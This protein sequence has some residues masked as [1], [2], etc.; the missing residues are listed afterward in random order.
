MGIS[1]Q[2]RFSDSNSFR[3]F[4]EGVEQL[5]SYEVNAKAD[6]LEKAADKLAECVANYP[7]ILPRLYLGI[8]RAEQ[9]EELEEAVHLL[10]EV[11]DRNVPELRTTATYYLAEAYLL[12]YTAEDIAYADTL[13]EQV[14]SGEAKNPKDRARIQELKLR[15]QGLRAFIYVREYLWKKRTD[16]GDLS[17]EHRKAV[18]R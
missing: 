3:L 15:S 8:V 18:H 9:G 5:Q 2:L 4:T 16:A 13:L 7:D 14:E 1:S 6:S 10:R 11:L 12:K 17:E